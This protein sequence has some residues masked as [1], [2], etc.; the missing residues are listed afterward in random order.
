MKLLLDVV[1]WIQEFDE[2]ALSMKTICVR[3]PW[4]AHA[5]SCVVDLDEESRIPQDASTGGYEY[6]LEASVA[7][8]VL[9]VLRDRLSKF[10]TEDA[11]RLLIYYAEK[12]AYPEWIMNELAM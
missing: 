6:F 4:T 2:S 8:E 7:R 1:A 9:D 5:E 11:C 10:T 3:K 12:D